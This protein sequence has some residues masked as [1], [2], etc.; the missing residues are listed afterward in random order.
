MDNN[1]YKQKLIDTGLFKKASGVHQYR[2]QECYYCGDNKN[3]FYV[4]IDLNSNCP[5][6]FNCFKC[7]LGEDK[8]T[9]IL[10]KKFL[11]YHN[12]DGINIPKSTSKRIYSSKPSDDIP[13]LKV[14]LT[15]HTREISDYIN[16]RVGVIP[17]INDLTAFQFIDDPV[18]YARDNLGGKLS[19]LEGRAWFRLTNG[20]I[21]GRLYNDKGMRWI[22][23]HQSQEL[24]KGL[25]T[26]KKDVDLRKE[27]NV[28]I[29]EGIIDIIG[30]YYYYPCD[31]SLFLAT[32][33]SNYISGLDHLLSI[34]V[35]GEMINVKIFKDQGAKMPKIDNFL[36]QLFGKIEIY[37]NRAAKDYGVQPHLLEIEK[38]L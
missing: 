9:K 18:N 33:S 38:I 11:E 10:N 6:V 37:R 3:H 24:Q 30:L 27:I 4:R 32:L 25:Y 19:M 2:M 22:N 20:N 26:I 15:D 8:R 7:N 28:I 12:I 17:T 5:V 16:Q 29:A 21:K 23:Y 36:R 34:G 35:F 14:S 31:N 13:I 1:D